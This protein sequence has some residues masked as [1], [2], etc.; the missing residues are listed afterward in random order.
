MCEMKRMKY[1]LLVQIGWLF[2]DATDGMASC[3]GY[4][5]LSEY[6]LLPA[7]GYNFIQSKCETQR[8]P[9]KQYINRETEW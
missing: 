2:G 9:D 1:K 3:C 6:V 7:H 4:I 5:L 8:W